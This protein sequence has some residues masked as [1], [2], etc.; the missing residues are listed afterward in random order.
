MMERQ[1]TAANEFSDASVSQPGEIMVNLVCLETFLN[2]RLK[3]VLDFT[4]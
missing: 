4:Q 2:L 1:S 3:S